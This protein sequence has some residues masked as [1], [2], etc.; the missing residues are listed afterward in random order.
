MIMA[1]FQWQPSDFTFGGNLQHKYP[2]IYITLKVSDADTSYCIPTFKLYTF[3]LKP[4]IETLHICHDYQVKDQI[5]IRQTNVVVPVLHALQIE[6]YTLYFHSLLP[7][8]WK[9]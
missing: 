1:R 6:L 8:V 5:A 4:A 9:M 3:L 7:D 2:W